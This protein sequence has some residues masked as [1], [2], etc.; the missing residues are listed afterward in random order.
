MSLTVIGL[1]LS[2][3]STGAVVLSPGEGQG[4]LRTESMVIKSKFKGEA[5]L[6]HLREQIMALVSLNQPDLIVI[7]G[8]AFGRPNAMAPL[9]E[10]GGVVKHS[11]YVDGWKYLIVP[12]TRVKK[13]ACGKG[14]AAKDEVRLGVFKR[15]GFEAKTNDE[16]DAYALARIGLAYLGL[17]DELIKPQI[18]VVKDLKKS[19]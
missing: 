1:D 11:L 19:A 18:E 16:V 10:L 8:Y 15:W 7:E 14:N 4:G 9:A 13:F 5:R 3:T 12:P 17:D 6:E 2:L